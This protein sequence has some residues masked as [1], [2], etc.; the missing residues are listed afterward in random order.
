LALP[1]SPLPFLFL[2]RLLFAGVCAP[3]KKSAPTLLR[4]GSRGHGRVL[5][6]H[7]KQRCSSTTPPPPPPQPAAAATTTAGT[8]AETAAAWTTTSAGEGAVAAGAATAATEEGA[9]A[10][11]ANTARR[12]SA[13]IFSSTASP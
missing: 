7:D 3:N 2:K 11:E 10:A 8:A 12:V 1:V 9:A 4:E 6:D 5:R 13:L